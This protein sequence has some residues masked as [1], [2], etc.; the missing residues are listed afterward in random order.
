MICRVYLATLWTVFLCATAASAED[1]IGMRL[2][3]AVG[4]FEKATEKARGNLVADLRKKVTAA[5]SAGDLR[6][7]ERL[8]AEA[9]AFEDKGELPKSVPIGGFQREMR[10]ARTKLED[11]YEA[12]VREYTQTDQ[13]ELAKATQQQL[14][15]LQK[16]SA[17]ALYKVI[18][19][20]GAVSRLRN[21]G[22]CPG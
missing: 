20:G 4:D 22:E 12:A 2:T 21:G 9:A 10:Q 19:G 3:S 14:D 18:E 16:G 11:A 5:K 6:T 1:A 17:N 7:L 8:E 13:H 15:D